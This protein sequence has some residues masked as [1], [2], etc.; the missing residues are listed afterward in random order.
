MTCPYHKAHPEI[1]YSFMIIGVC[2]NCDAVK[3]GTYKGPAECQC[4][5]CEFDRLKDRVKKLEEWKEKN[6]KKL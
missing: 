2:S 5:E 4:H 3:N 6:E 1:T